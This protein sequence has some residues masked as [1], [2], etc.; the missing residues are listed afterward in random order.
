VVIDLARSFGREG[1]RRIDHE[2]R[3]RGL[4]AWVRLTP[5]E[6]TSIMLN[7]KKYVSKQ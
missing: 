1:R 3:R 4:K 5:P 7:R 2:P 6:G